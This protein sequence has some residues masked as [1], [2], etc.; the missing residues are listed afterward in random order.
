MSLES[1]E[2]MAGIEQWSETLSSPPDGQVHLFSLFME[3][4]PKL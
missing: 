1:N 2:V 3:V 4:G